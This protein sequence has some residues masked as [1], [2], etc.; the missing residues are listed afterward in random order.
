LKTVG[1]VVCELAAKNTDGD[2]IR[3]EFNTTIEKNT[4]Y[5]IHKQSNGGLQL[6]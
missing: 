3:K 2:L 5:Y 1:K 6:R 4:P